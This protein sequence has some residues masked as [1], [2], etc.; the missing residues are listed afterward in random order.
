MVWQGLSTL[1]PLPA[2]RGSLLGGRGLPVSIKIDDSFMSLEI[3][4]EVVATAC[5]VGRPC[6]ASEPL[7]HWPWLSP[8]RVPRRLRR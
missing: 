5:T 7:E 8:V 4:G 6:A 3:D 1:A 2:P